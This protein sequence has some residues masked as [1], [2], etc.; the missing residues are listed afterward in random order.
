MYIYNNVPEKKF[1]IFLNISLYIY[2]FLLHLYLTFNMLFLTIYTFL[3]HINHIFCEI[4]GKNI[5]IIFRIF[6]N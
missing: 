2:L 4:L 6:K 5:Y 3:H 1:Q